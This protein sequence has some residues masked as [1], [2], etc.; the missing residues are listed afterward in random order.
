M[1]KTTV[2]THVNTSKTAKII[3]SDIIH[4]TLSF[5]QYLVGNVTFFMILLFSMC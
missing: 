4:S 3:K 5:R 1:Y 2:Y